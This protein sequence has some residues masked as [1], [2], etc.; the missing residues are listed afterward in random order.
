MDDDI[1]IVTLVATGGLSP[2]DVSAASDAARSAVAEPGPIAWLERG[3][4]AEFPVVGSDRIALR[5][6]IEALLPRADVF[7][8]PA[9]RDHR[10]FVADMDSTMITVECIDEL[11]DYVGLKAEVSAVTEAAM[12]GEIDFAEALRRRVA[13]LE[14]LPVS[15]IE[16]CLRARVVAS[17]GAKTLV[18]TLR[19]RGMRTLLVSGGFTRFAEPVARDIGFDAAQ[20]NVLE[21]HGDALT[22]RVVQPIVDAR[23]KA[24]AVVELARA[25]GASPKQAVAIGDGANDVMM[26][27]AAGL[28]VA[29]HAK[30]KLAEAAVARIRNGDLTVLLHALGIARAD[31]VAA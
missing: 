25:A 12:R 16:D 11:A 20:A 14:G 27:E 29:Y 15:A 18:R 13:V 28:G 26:I 31:W 30:P 24:A 5:D 2:G 19:A 10:L 8:Q 22:G 17:P 7:V 1:G 3:T 21:T 6:T 23:V 9:A 4:A